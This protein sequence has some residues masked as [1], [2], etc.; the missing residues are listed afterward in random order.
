MLINC[1]N[2][3]KE[4]SDNL[5]K[6]PICGFIIKGTSKNKM[7]LIASCVIGFLILLTI[8]TTV[9]PQIIRSAEYD[10][11]LKQP[12]PFTGVWYCSR[13]NSCNDMEIT[14]TISKLNLGLSLDRNMVC[15]H[16]VGSSHLKETTFFPKTNEI[17]SPFIKGKFVLDN[18]YLYEIFIDGKQN[19]YT[20][21]N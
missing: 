2:C 6:C 21:V 15:D 20:R 11:A 3:N 17:D 9:I 16:G 18:N 4:M 7:Y 1:P 19:R 14:L 10:R 8:G 12:S 5:K 13:E